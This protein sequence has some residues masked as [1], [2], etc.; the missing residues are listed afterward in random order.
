MASERY[1]DNTESTL[2]NSDER[3]PEDMHDDENSPLLAEDE[4]SDEG[5]HDD[6]SH[7]QTSA[8]S[9]LLR[10]IRTPK[11]G[12][13]SCLKRWPSILALALL[14]IIGIVILLMGFVAPQVAKEYAQ[15]AATFEPT[16]LSIDSYTDS[17]VVARVQGQ[18]SMQPAKVHKQAVRNLGRFGAWVARYVEI[19]STDVQVSLP[20]HDG[21]VLGTASVPSIT[22]GLTSGRITPIDVLVN[23]YPGPQDGLRQ[24]AK[25]WVDGQFDDYVA[26]ARA[27][28]PV[29]SG[30][31]HLG[32]QFI[33]QTVSLPGKP[34][35]RRC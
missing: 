13:R 18:F 7:P 10:C 2:R 24:V 17:G 1:S 5:Y 32:K 3:D 6:H 4:R 34:P 15:Q 31:L 16:R 22:L 21:I 33:S 11:D 20:G 8:V 23:L 19:G 12:K 35:S 14:C 26:E 9:S 28:V 25:E 30:I 27:E 29:R